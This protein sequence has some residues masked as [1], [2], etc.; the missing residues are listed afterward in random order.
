[1][2]GTEAP[3]TLLCITAMQL[4]GRLV[5]CPCA[6]RLRSL[7]QKVLLTPGLRHFSRIFPDKACD[8][9][10]AMCIS[11][12]QARTKRVAQAHEMLLV[13]CPGAFPLRKLAQN[14]RRMPTFDSM[15]NMFVDKSQH[16]FGG[17]RNLPD[18]TW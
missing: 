6:F 3:M 14:I 11:I 15:P 1:M 5:T 12:A 8:T 7:A 9:S 18:L 16:S 2:D 4:P 10:I 17:K 13:T